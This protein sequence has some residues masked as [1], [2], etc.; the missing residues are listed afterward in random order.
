[1]TLTLS[2]TTTIRKPSDLWLK[3]QKNHR[4]LMQW[5]LC[6]IQDKIFGNILVE[7]NEISAWWLC[8]LSF[9][10]HLFPVWAFIAAHCWFDS[11]WKFW[12]HNKHYIRGSTLEKFSQTAV[13]TI[14]NVSATTQCSEMKLWYFMGNLMSNHIPEH[15]LCGLPSVWWLRTRKGFIEDKSGLASCNCSVPCKEIYYSSQLSWSHFPSTNYARSMGFSQSKTI[16][17]FPLNSLMYCR[18]R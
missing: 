5:S 10:N 9:R 6:K 14:I 11:A 4:E 16:L 7:Y 13:N 17:Q 8:N 15:R 1:M 3:I 18:F 12:H 2:R